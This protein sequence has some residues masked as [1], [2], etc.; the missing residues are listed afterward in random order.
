MLRLLAV[1]L[2]ISQTFAQIYLS[3]D[4]MFDYPEDPSPSY[5]PV[6]ENYP[7]VLPD[8]RVIPY[9]PQTYSYSRQMWNGCGCA[10]A[11][12][13]ADYIKSRPRS[14]NQ[15]LLSYYQLM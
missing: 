11:K 9:P 15:K 10:T 5:V 6:F 1:L 12:T 14:R 4:I 2:I 3:N 7:D 8:Y 13:Y